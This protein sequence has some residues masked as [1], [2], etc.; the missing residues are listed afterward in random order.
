MSI[1]DYNHDGCLHG[2]PEWSERQL[3]KVLAVSGCPSCQVERIAELEAL[4]QSFDAVDKARQAENAKL[5]YRLK[6][7]HKECETC[8][9]TALD[10][11]GLN[12]CDGCGQ[13]IWE[14]EK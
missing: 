7:T 8:T 3:D 4:V 10:T 13:K 2:F 6:H 9:M 12:I 11:T 14:G 1:Q 5:E